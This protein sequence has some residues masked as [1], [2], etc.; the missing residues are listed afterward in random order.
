MWETII[1]IVIAYLPIAV[2]LALWNVIQL[3]R[4]AY[5]SIKYEENFKNHA[6]LQNAT[7]EPAIES[8]YRMVKEWPPHSDCYDWLVNEQYFKENTIMFGHMGGKFVSR[9][10][11]AFI[12]PFIAIQKFSLLFTSKK[13]KKQ[14]K[15]I[16]FV[17]P[18]LGILASYTVC[19]LLDVTEYGDM[20]DAF[21]AALQEW[22]LRLLQT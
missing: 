6:A 2:I 21:A 13:Q 9:I 19:R 14:N 4:C 10:F 15:V 7:I 3:I 16:T 1:R 18:L 12:W 22:V 17:R 20:L 11:R 8:L 5:Y